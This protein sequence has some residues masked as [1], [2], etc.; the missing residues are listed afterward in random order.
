MRVLGNDSQRFGSCSLDFDFP[1][2]VEVSLRPVFD[3]FA[4]R[5]ISS[6]WVSR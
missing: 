4:Q 5:S 3:F 2:V 1:T 6:Y